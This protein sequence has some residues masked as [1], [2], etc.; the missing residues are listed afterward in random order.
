MLLQEVFWW[1]LPEG[2]ECTPDAKCFG[3]ASQSDTVTLTG[4]VAGEDY[5]FYIQTKSHDLLSAVL[6]INQPTFTDDT[7]DGPPGL[8]V[9]ETLE[10]ELTFE[11]KFESGTGS[12]TK[13]SYLG[14]LSES[15]GSHQTPFSYVFKALCL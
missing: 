1:Y 10:R 2:P 12:I 9:L 3:A 5:T 8:Q 6:D 7:L 11:V 4:L 15:T 13:F 14:E